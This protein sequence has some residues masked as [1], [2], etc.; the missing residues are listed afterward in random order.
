MHS[1]YWCYC[2]V[3]MPC[4]AVVRLTTGVISDKHFSGLE[5]VMCLIGFANWNSDVGSSQNMKGRHLWTKGG[6]HD[7]REKYMEKG[8]YIKNR[9]VV[10]LTHRCGHDNRRKTTAIKSLHSR[11]VDTV[12]SIL[13]VLLAWQSNQAVQSL[14]TLPRRHSWTLVRL[15]QLGRWEGEHKHHQQTSRTA[16]WASEVDNQ[17]TSHPPLL[18]KAK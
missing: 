11:R 8:R 6:I 9:R 1:V 17:H 12:D 16:R 3:F 14:F 2:N 7:Q 5:F 18:E 13:L 4:S 10:F 15:L